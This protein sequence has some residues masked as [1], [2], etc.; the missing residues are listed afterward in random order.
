[1]VLLWRPQAPLEEV[2]EGASSA[3]VEA[4]VHGSA[5]EGSVKSWMPAGL[6]F[7]GDPEAS[8]DP[9]DELDRLLRERGLKRAYAETEG[10][11]YEIGRAI[12][13]EE[14]RRCPSS[15]DSFLRAVE[16]PEG[17]RC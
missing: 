8:E 12:D 17:A 10:L 1:M 9:M 5:V 11:A 3:G 15:F 6:G 7:R 13:L 16:D 2:L 14:A 4:R